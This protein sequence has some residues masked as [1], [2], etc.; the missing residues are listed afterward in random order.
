MPATARS[1]LL[2]S[3]GN[4]LDLSVWS[5]CPVDARMDSISA[6]N[7]QADTSRSIRIM[8]GM[9][10]SLVVEDLRG[11]REDSAKAAA[12][13]RFAQYLDRTGDVS[14]GGSDW[15]YR[16]LVQEHHGEVQLE[17]KRIDSPWTFCLT[18]LHPGRLDVRWTEAGDTAVDRGVTYD[19]DGVERDLETFLRRRRSARQNDASAHKRV[20]AEPGRLREMLR[21][22]AAN[23]RN[24]RIVDDAG[25]ADLTI[26]SRLWATGRSKDGVW[27]GEGHA[28]RAAQV[29]RVHDGLTLSR[30]TRR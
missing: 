11:A 7:A 19:L 21:Q 14:T 28:E 25:D 4:R 24:V 27:Y 10:Y 13:E 26:E 3:L 9:R 16:L 29:R 17:T 12:A 2:G 20:W 5:R 23:R 6:P 1:G 18:V 15:D 30:G 22:I 8:A